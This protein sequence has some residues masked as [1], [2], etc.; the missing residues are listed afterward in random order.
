MRLDAAIVDNAEVAHTRGGQVS[1]ARHAR[2][3]S[4]STVILCCTCYA[5]GVDNLNGREVVRVVRLD[6]A[7]ETIIDQL[8]RKVGPRDVSA[9]S[10]HS[11]P[12][13]I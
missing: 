1:A 12:P 4:L 3:S 2:Y 10:Y 5:Q 7:S 13:H 9:L 11:R 8:D 6:R